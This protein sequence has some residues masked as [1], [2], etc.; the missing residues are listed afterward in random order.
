MISQIWQRTSARD[1]AIRQL[2]LARTRLVA[3]LANSSRQPGQFAT[4]RVGPNLGLG[5]DGDALS[6]LSS[7]D[8]SGQS[9]WTVDPATGAATPA[10]QITYYLVVPNAP[11]A[12]SCVAG[13]PDAS[14]YEQQ[15]PF[16]WLIRRVDP[17]PAPPPTI[18]SSWTTF[19][20][21]PTAIIQTPARQV[22]ADQLLQFRVFSAAPTWT[23][24]LSAV[25]VSEATRQ[26]TL[27]SVPL[28]QSKY[29]LVEQ[30][31]IPAH[32]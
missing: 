9:T 24:R 5:Y 23:I 15:C 22:V 19:L 27:G 1:D 16:K 32:N 21:R 28:S 6:F 2:H 18:A 3:D 12:T 10:A 14:G 31:S 11:K 13:A 25:A 17:A 4:A 29:T 7:D 30:F 26:I 20:T 8:G